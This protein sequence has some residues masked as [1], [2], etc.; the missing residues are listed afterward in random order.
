MTKTAAIAPSAIGANRISMFHLYEHHRL[1]P[2]SSRKPK[3]K[4]RKE[5][6]TPTRLTKNPAQT[7]TVTICNTPTQVCGAIT[8]ASATD[9]TMKTDCNNSTSPARHT[10]QIGRHAKTAR[11]RHMNRDLDETRYVKIYVGEEM[12][13]LARGLAL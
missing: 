2:L 4:I 12:L 5:R 10:T 3:P 6:R 11:A 9:R 1:A 8:G 13:G 7:P